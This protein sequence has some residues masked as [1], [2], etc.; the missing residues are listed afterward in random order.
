MISLI[1][2]SSATHLMSSEELL[3]ILRISQMKNE[4]RAVT[5]MLLYMSGNFMQVLEGDEEAVRETYEKILQDDRHTGVT[6]LVEEPIVERQFEK[7]TMAFRNLDEEIARR[8]RAFSEFLQD[9][10]TGDKY[11]EKPELAYK[12]LLRFKEDMR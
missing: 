5:G 1:Y 12:M 7:W 8:E 2:V 9:E 3:N 4:E 10:F 11:R 6:L